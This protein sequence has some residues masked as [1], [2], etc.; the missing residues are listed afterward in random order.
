MTCIKPRM[1]VLLVTYPIYRTLN[2]RPITI[3]KGR[4]SVQRDG[5]LKWLIH[6]LLTQPDLF[7][8]CSCDSLKRSESKERFFP[9]P[10]RT[11]RSRIGHR[12]TLVTLCYVFG[13]FSIL[14]FKRAHLN[15]I[16]NSVKCVLLFK[17]HQLFHLH[18]N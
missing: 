5:L 4:F 2:Y 9:K 11:V 16:C 12:L 1:C 18:L 17:N 10:P 7:T 8:N 6:A 14:T 13:L 3:R 15:H